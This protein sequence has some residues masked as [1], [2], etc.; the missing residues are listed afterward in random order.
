MT[1]A[2]QKDRI[3]ELTAKVDMMIPICEYTKVLDEHRVASQKINKMQS[4]VNEL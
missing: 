4:D 2:D 1:N 3:S